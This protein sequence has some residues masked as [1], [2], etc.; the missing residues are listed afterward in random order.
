MGKQ[1]SEMILNDEDDIESFLNEMESF[2]N[3]DTDIF[4]TLESWGVEF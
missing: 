4:T 2:E 1:F 3:L